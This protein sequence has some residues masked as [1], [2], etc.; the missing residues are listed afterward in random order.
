MVHVREDDAFV[1]GPDDVSDVVEGRQADE[2]GP[3][4]GDDRRAVDVGHEERVVF[5][6]REVED[7]PLADLE[8][9]PVVQLLVPE[10]LE[11]L[12]D[13]LADEPVEVA[14]PVRAGLEDEPRVGDGVGHREEHVLGGVEFAGD[15]F[16]DRPRAGDDAQLVLG[17]EPGGQCAGRDVHHSAGHRGPLD[18]SGEFG[19][20]LRHVAR[21]V[22][23]AAQLRD[24][25]H[26]PGQPQ[27]VEDVGVESQGAD[28]EEA[29]GRA[30]G[31]LDR[32]LPRQAEADEVLRAQDVV[33]SLPHVGLVRVQPRQQGGRLAGPDLGSGLGPHP[34]AELRVGHPFVHDGLGPPVRRDDPRPH[35][36]PLSVDEV[37]AVAVAGHCEGGDLRGV[38]AGGLQAAADRPDVGLPE[39]FDV[40]F[41]EQGLGGQGVQ[42]RLI[43]GDDRTVRVVDRGLGE[44]AAVIYAEDIAGCHEDSFVLLSFA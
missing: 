34:G 16:V 7:H 18:Q 1:H 25:P 4:V 33:G 31:R 43:E 3:T 20:L 44:C 32:R 2:L 9:F 27:E 6:G 5:A 39:L 38:D 40:A 14:H 37:E 42:V 26:P 10:A 29:D 17:Y 41:G 11:G 15:D 12:A 24:L 23:R 35:A 22:G 21:D 8:D 28:V 30:V 36:A 19:R 13:D